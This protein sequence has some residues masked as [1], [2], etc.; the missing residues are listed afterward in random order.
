MMKNTTAPLALILGLAVGPLWAAPIDDELAHLQHGWAQAYYQVPEAQ[1]KARFEALAQEAQTLVSRYPN[2]AEPLVW[3][4]IVLSTQAKVVGGLS[5]LDKVKRARERLLAAEKMDA[6]VLDGSVYASLGSLYAKVPGWPL[7]FGD[8]QKAR[9]YL[10]QALKLNPDG[11]DPNFFYAD[12][13]LDQGDRDAAARYFRKALAAPPRPGRE[14]AD[15]GRRH[16]IEA[17]LAKLSS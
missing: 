9:T 8:K 6:E 17:A 13:M 2:R 12:L 16:E 5:A 1:Q 7:A 4:G 11:I 15:A 3:E 14:D 10:E